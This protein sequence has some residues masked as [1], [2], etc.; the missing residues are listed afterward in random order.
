MQKV[1][2]IYEDLAGEVHIGF[3]AVITWP[4]LVETSGNSKT[5]VGNCFQI[6]KQ[7]IPT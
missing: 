3:L 1:L 7:K 4:F 2:E 5:N 6:C